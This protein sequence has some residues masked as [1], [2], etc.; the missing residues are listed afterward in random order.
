[1]QKQLP[2]QRIVIIGAGFAGISMAKSFKNKEVDVLV[3]DQNNF[4]NF[5]PLLYQIA[6]GGLE[7]YSI[8]YPVRRILRGSKNIRFRM[9]KVDKINAVA[10]N[11]ETSL[12]TIA[13]DELII[14]TGSQTNFFNFTEATKKHLL[15]LKSVPEALDIR[16]F[17]FQNLERSLV[18]WEGE[19][20][21]E[22]ISIAVVGGGPAGIEVAGALAEM[23]KH[24][25]PKDFPDLDVSKMQIHIYQSS[26]KLLKGMSNEASEKSK[27]FLEEMG[28]DVKLNSRVVGYDGDL[29]ELKTGETFKTDTVIWAAG[30]KGTLIEGLADTSIAK[31]DRI[32]VDEYNRVV[33]A[34]SIYAIG[35][36][37]THITEENPYG[38]PM[39]APVAQ[40]QGE[41][42]AK[43]ILAVIK[44][45]VMKPFK[46]FDKG[47][48]ATIGR[49]KAVVD[50]PK[51]KF[52]G[53]FAWYVWMFVHIFS[54]VG[55]RNKLVAIIDWMA[56]YFTYDRPLGLI[57]RRFDK[58]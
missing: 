25:I 22:I 30:V 5:Q 58:K 32:K 45:G 47:S 41:T 13:Y 26:P 31:G 11:L 21:D 29:L 40:Q 12:G 6:T 19:T 50:L 33:G 53:A 54:L 9:A 46:Y 37:A 17:I 28:V 7:P 34:E 51:F 1:M 52:Q 2:K 8:A 38:L 3:L 55:F 4:H 15:S 14:A 23:K 44:G 57:I 10:K 24:V 48:M 56:N 43:N 16:S 35:D 36:V 18:K 49:N 42:L 39:L 20:V 27:E